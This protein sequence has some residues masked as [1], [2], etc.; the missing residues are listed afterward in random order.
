MQKVGHEEYT[1]HM[2]GDGHTD[3]CTAT[4]L[5]RNEGV[6]E[7]CLNNPRLEDQKLQHLSVIARLRLHMI[8][9]S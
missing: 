9:I 8:F 5:M 7:R 3:H 4:S 6:S 1:V 2:D